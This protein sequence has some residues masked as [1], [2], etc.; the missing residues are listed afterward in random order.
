MRELLL[1]G[2]REVVPV[3]EC[4]TR[5]ADLLL[6]TEALCVTHV[7]SVNEAMRSTAA[8]RLEQ[9]RGDARPAPTLDGGAP[10][11]RAELRSRR[12]V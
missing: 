5:G 10:G 8:E 12:R 9:T 3:L 6:G 4:L 11:R 7:T 1:D 2:D